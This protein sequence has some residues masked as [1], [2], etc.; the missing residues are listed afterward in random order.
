[1]GQTLDA[2]RTLPFSPHPPR[3]ETQDERSETIDGRREKQDVRRKGFYVLRLS[4]CVY[5]LPSFRASVRKSDPWA[6]LRFLLYRRLCGLIRP[7]LPGS[8]RISLLGEY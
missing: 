4:S 8:G 5:R 6:C 1:M 2:R 3:R 7:C